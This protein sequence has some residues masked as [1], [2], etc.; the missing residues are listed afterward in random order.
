ME[1]ITASRARRTRGETQIVRRGLAIPDKLIDWLITL[2]LEA[3]CSNDDLRIPRDLIVLIR[4]RIGGAN[5]EY[6]K[7]AWAHSNKGNAALV[8]GQL[9]AQGKRPT[10]KLLAN[11]SALRRAR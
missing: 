5:R 3:M 4:E 1:K 2:S 10:Y 8:A 9:S 7:A 11:C 6:E